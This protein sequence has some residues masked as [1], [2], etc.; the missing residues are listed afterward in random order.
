MTPAAL[1]VSQNKPSDVDALPMVPQ[2]TSPPSWLNALRTPS[3]R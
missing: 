1:M 3:E 2:A